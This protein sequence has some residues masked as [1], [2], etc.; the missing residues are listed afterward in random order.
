M[1]DWVI[2]FIFGLFHGFGFASGLGDLGLTGEFLTLS[3]LGFNIGVE[4]G[5]LVII[6][7]IFPVLYF[8]RKHKF[9][10]QLL[11]YMS[12]L[13]I[14]ISLYWCVERVFD[15]NLLLDDYLIKYAYNLA[16][17]LGIK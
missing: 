11:V 16:K 15:I 1:K 5:Q 6:A 17:W 7:V 8:F 12:V 4:V 9:Y 14:I 13:L 10:P 2:A 3:L